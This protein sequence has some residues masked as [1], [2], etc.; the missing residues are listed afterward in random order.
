MDSA[1]TVEGKISWLELSVNGA[2]TLSFWWKVDCEHDDS[3]ECT[4]DRGMCFVDGNQ[5]AIASIDGK[6]DWTRVEVPFSD[7]GRH[8]VKI[9]FYKDADQDPDYIGE[10]CVWAG[11]VVWTGVGSDP[12]PDIGKNPTVQQIQNAL[13][14]SA[15]KKLALRITDGFEYLRYREWALKIG[16]TDVKASPFA[17]ASFAT[18]SAALLAKMPT[19]EDLKVEE[20]KPS[21]TAG[22]FDFTVSVKDVKIGDKASEDNLKKLFGLEG[23]ESLDA[24][25]FSSENVSLDFKEPQDGKLKFTATPAVDN[26]KSF[27]M[28]VKVK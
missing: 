4:W 26:A 9:T 12:I 28:K 22:A 8:V 1:T 21:P 19:D 15:D 14:G 27:F 3:G 10:D 2:G 11:K 25:A 5:V 13:E 23:A 6:K 7:L 17:W 24:A 16:A 18:D 20:F